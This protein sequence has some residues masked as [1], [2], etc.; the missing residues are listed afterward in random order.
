MRM[1]LRAEKFFNICELYMYI[2]F[3]SIILFEKK[4]KERRKGGEDKRGLNEI[5]IYISNNKLM[6]IK[7]GSKFYCLYNI[8]LL[9]WKLLFEFMNGVKGQVFISE[10]CL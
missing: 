5:F 1:W 7:L 9:L 3:F 2:L 10:N 6:W 4:R 8:V